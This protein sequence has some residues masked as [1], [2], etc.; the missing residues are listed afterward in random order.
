[1]IE[2]W[3]LSYLVNSIWQV[4]LLLLVGWVA[5]RAL[6]QAGPAA[7]HRVWVSVLVLQS[8]L[9]LF[10]TLP[11]EWMRSLLI[12]GGALSSGDGHVTVLMGPG[13]G[14]GAGRFP[15]QLPA[16]IAIAYGAICVYLAA[17]FIWQWRKLYAIRAE[18]VEVQPSP[19]IALLWREC[20]NRFRISGVTLAASSRI[21]GPV[22]MGFQRKLVL[23]PGN[24]VDRLPEAEVH[25][26]LA[27]EFAHIRRNDFAKNLIYEL[28]GLTVSYH[29]LFHMTRQRMR[30]SREIVCDQMAAEVGGH[31]QYARSLLRLASLLAGGVPVRTP[32]ALGI[33]D[34]KTFER[35][36]MKLSEKRREIRAVRRL[37]IVAACAAFGVAACGSALALGVQVDAATSSAASTN[38]AQGHSQPLHVSPGIMAGQRVSGP[39]PKYPEA[40]KKKKIQGTVV[41][42]ALVGKDGS[43]KS[44]KALSGPKELRDSAI[45]AVRQWKYKPYLL[46]GEPV[47]VTTKINVIYSLGKMGK[48]SPR[49]PKG[50]IPPP[51]PPP[52]PPHS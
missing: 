29:P 44:V 26:V 19:E 27:H 43:V 40:A 6:R 13:V 31:R 30:E 10:S 16:A 24:M 17:R 38:Q 45:D 28:L 23:L 52:P 7:E 41:L 34:T 25:A 35:R 51:P 11:R 33:F 14:V 2:S 20:L 21:S 12:Y 49:G 48:T 42:D 15:A 22:T 36:I 5:A 37:A 46:N 32:H 9:P 1:M 3:I 8:V 47:E 50:K 4:P 18:S 39:N